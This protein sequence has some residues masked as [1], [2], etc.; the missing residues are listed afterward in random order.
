[1]KPTLRSLS[2]AFLSLLAAPWIPAQTSVS[3]SAP[4]EAAV[5]L[6]PFEVKEGAD[7]GY[8]AA[9]TLAGTRLASNI[10][11]IAAQVTVMTPEFLQDIAATTLEEAMIY[12][13]NVENRQEYT[14][15]PSGDTLRGTQDLTSAQRVRG[16]GTANNTRDFFTTHFSLDT[17]NSERFTFNSG[18]NAI[19]FGL[20]SPGGIID[21]T[22][23]RARFRDAV[24]IATR[25]DSFD[26]YRGSLD[27]NRVIVP[28][29]L[30]V[31]GSLL[32]D[33]GESW[34]K[35]S[36]DLQRRQFVTATITPFAATTVRVSFE[37][38]R[39]EA[40]IPRN[41]LTRD[42]V[43]PYLAWRQQRMQQLGLSDPLDPRLYWAPNNVLNPGEAPFATGAGT[44]FS[45][46][47]NTFP[48]LMTGLL[49]P[50]TPT[51][52]LI[53][54]MTGAVSATNPVG[55]AMRS[56]GP[57]EDRAAP[58]N[59]L[60]SLTDKSIMPY[61]VNIGGLGSDNHQ[62]GSIGNIA[63][64]HQFTRNFIVEGAFQTENYDQLFNDWM[65]GLDHNLQI[66][67]NR[68]LPNVR[69]ANGGPVLNPNRGKYYVENNRG[70]SN[71]QT[72]HSRQARLTASYKLDF[73]RKPGWQRWLGSHG[74]AGLLD[75]STSV[76]RNQNGRESIFSDTTSGLPFTLAANRNAHGL[77]RRVY[78]DSVGGRQFYDVNED[79]SRLY[80]QP[81]GT[82]T[83]ITTEQHPTDR[84]KGL[85]AVGSISR[86]RTS[87]QVLAVQSQFWK[88]R[89]FVTYGRRKDHYLSKEIVTPFVDPTSAAATRP[90][91]WNHS[92][93]V[94]RMQAPSLNG[95]V[96]INQDGKQ[97]SRGIVVKPLR[98][99]AAHYNESSN[100]AAGAPRL[101]PN[102]GYQPSSSGEG[103][104][105]GFSVNLPGNRL[106]LKINWYES[107]QL[108]SGSS[109]FGGISNQVRIVEERSGRIAEDKP[110]AGFRE[111]PT[112]NAQV[113]WRNTPVLSDLESKGLE[114]SLVANPLRNLRVSLTAAK[115]TAAETNIARDWVAYVAARTPEWSK[116]YNESITDSGDVSFGDRSVKQFIDDQIGF[117][118]TTATLV[119]GR[120][121]DAVRKWRVNLV[122][123]YSFTAGFLRDFGVG[124]AVRWR[125]Q[126]AI[127]LPM[128][129]GPNG[130]PVQDIYNPY[131]DNGLLDFDGWLSY[132]TK[133]WK[134]NVRARFQLNVRNLL[135]TRDLLPQ[136][137]DTSGVARIFTVQP[138]RQFIFSA[139]FDL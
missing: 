133:L 72:G 68:Y 128:K 17:F 79:V 82:A 138:P 32:Y 69:A 25:V 24:Q 77:T 105:Y 95:P 66:D 89:I 65:R 52:S 112:W 104:D 113:D 114:I 98:F 94:E 87:G 136:R 4:R 33:H 16:L 92:V 102:G 107:S 139:T 134:D 81:Y 130:Q 99:L 54:R 83:S 131:F 109:E 115:T 64:E 49:S 44:P 42:F 12:S 22:L 123:N 90:W 120:P 10:E 3:P 91:Y 108:A 34:R 1:M 59:F 11:D 127:G 111:S 31:R 38:I 15:D 2:P 8:A 101:S 6:S 122:S 129:P 103:K 88:D 116:F 30:A 63:I 86:N 110:E 93:D 118:L 19:L 124:G 23:K 97:E 5:I 37:H 61:D 121:S 47:A 76:A 75:Y 21:Q 41:T 39:R 96:D 43:S 58:D 135:D 7:T 67:V 27:V 106:G 71:L 55:S 70:R 51:A 13:L 119:D 18:P 84:D 56:R 126:A 73:T 78:L 45:L 14:A 40:A 29:K 137:A 74:L 46:N 53:N 60:Y 28:G 35:P 100:F 48:L 26:G 57:N 62:Q 20:G 50:D 125:D 9:Q 80:E 132:R 36:R 85:W 117:P